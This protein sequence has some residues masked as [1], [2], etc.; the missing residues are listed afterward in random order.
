MRMSRILK[1]DVW[2]KIFTAVNRHESIFLDRDAVELFNRTVREI[3]NDRNSTILN[4]Q[5][6]NLLCI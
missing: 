6:R 5:T 3:R 2:Y 1:P 4:S